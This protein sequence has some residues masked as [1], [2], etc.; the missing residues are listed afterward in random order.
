MEKLLELA[1]TENIKV[2]EE[3]K[4]KNELEKAKE[5]ENKFY[6]SFG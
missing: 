3:Y 6:S 5:Q 1:E 4:S 2:V